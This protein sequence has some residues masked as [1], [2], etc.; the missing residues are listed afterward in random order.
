MIKGLIGVAIDEKPVARESNL[1]WKTYRSRG[2]LNSAMSM[3]IAE[4][5]RRASSLWARGETRRYESSQNSE[6]C[7]IVRTC[8]KLQIAKVVWSRT[9]WS[10]S[11]SLS[12]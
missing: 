2:S 9:S 4:L 12:P 5:S 7:G 6:D 11:W 3:V 1:T 10:S 8:R